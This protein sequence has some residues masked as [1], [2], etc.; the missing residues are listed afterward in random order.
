MI[1]IV[2]HPWITVGAKKDLVLSFSL[3]LSFS[4][5]LSPVQTL[6]FSTRLN[7][8]TQKITN[9]T[10]GH[11]EKEI[12]VCFPLA[13]LCQLLYVLIPSHNTTTQ[14]KNKWLFLLFGFVSFFSFETLVKWASF[15]SLSM[16][17]CLCFKSVFWSL[18]VICLSLSNCYRFFFFTNYVSSVNALSTDAYFR[19]SFFSCL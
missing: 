5:P 3:S 8:Y 7:C 17:V 18:L 16:C 14:S 13:H 2:F 9:Y 6:T 11:N 1:S 15:P 19:F 4:R 10:I 12:C